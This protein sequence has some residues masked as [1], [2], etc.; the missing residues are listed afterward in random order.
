MSHSEETPPSSGGRRHDHDHGHAHAH[1][2]DHDHDHPEPTPP[3][4]P[5][6]LVAADDAGAQALDEALRS[7]FVVVKFAMVAMVVIFFFSGVFIVKPQEKAVIFRFGHLVQSADQLLGPGLHFAFPP[8]IDEVRKIP[9]TELQVVRSTVGWFRIPPEL[10]GL[11]TDPSPNYTLDPAADGYTLTGDANIIHVKATLRYLITDPLAYSFHFTDA[12]NIVINILDNALFHASGRYT[13]DRALDVVTLKDAIY[14]RVTE[15]A[16]ALGLG[17][18]IQPPDVTV[19]AP[20]QTKE[21]FNAVVTASQNKETTNNVARSYANNVLSRALGDSNAVVNVGAA[22]AS[23]LV[24]DL[25]SDAQAVED[26]LPS[27]RKDSNL[28]YERR[29]AETMERV[30]TNATE[31]YYMPALAGGKQRELRLLLS[32]TPEKPASKDDSAASSGG[33]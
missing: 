27:Y 25:K 17:I 21:S 29:L 33:K 8:P 14:A 16:K 9:T 18:T 23:R 32:K 7:S 31:K 30:L 13:V 26:L 5:A 6:E 1:P 11:D 15:Q 22:D 10:A 24:A 3:A 20:L 2:H 19:K 4:S 28:F 12:S